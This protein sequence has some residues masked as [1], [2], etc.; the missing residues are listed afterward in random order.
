MK[1]LKLLSDKLNK[2]GYTTFLKKEDDLIYLKGGYS[3][4]DPIKSLTI[5]IKVLL[6]EGEFV[7]IDWE[8]QVSQRKTFSSII[9]TV[10]YIE[11]KYPI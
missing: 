1:E 9:E 8:K 3:G 7:F 5:D 10:K 4:D 2:R 6:E 11:E